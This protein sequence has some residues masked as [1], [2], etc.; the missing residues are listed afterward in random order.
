[1]DNNDKN[2]NNKKKVTLPKNISVKLIGEKVAN[3]LKEIKKPVISQKAKKNVIV[4]ASLFLIGAAVL[5]NWIM[6]SGDSE[7]KETIK[8]EDKTNIAASADVSDDSDY[9]TQTQISRQRA[10][11]E[12]IEVLQ[13]IVYSDDAVEDV[14]NE[15]L[16][17]ISQIA[18]NIE[19]EANIETLVVSKG[20]EECIAVVGNNSA[21]I[22]VKSDGLLDNQI[23]QIQEIVFEQTN[24]PVENMKIIE[25]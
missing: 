13:S 24:I 20:I 11:D 19:A 16:E 22:V 17:D 8:Q 15:A 14:K 10:R 5:L 9:F 7:D 23:T 4:T 18:R 3:K 21:T 12:S 2:D 6:F 1:M 25:K